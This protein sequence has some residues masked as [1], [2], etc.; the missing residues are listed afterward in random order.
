MR[1]AWAGK[2][3]DGLLFRVSTIDPL[4]QHAFATQTRFVTDLLDHIPAA[5]RHR[6][7]GL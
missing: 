2:R 3:T 5:D 1:M 7:S 6:L 4:A